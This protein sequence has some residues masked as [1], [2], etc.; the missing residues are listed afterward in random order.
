MGQVE[1]SWH[2]SALLHL[3]HNVQALAR[4]TRRTETFVH[5]PREGRTTRHD[6][7]KVMDRICVRYM[8]CLVE[9]VSVQSRSRR[10]PGWSK[11]VEPLV[12]IQH[13]RACWEGYAASVIN[14]VRTVTLRP[15]E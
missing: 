11:K 14:G 4:P 7:S 13:R 8:F 15:W 1:A 6:E 5:F 9:H 2:K 3:S 12:D 10:I